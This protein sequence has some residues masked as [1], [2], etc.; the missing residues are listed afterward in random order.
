MSILINLQD[1]H[2]YY[3]CMTALIYEFCTPAQ[4][5]FSLLVWTSA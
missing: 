4:L 5:S 2:N 3:L 1:V